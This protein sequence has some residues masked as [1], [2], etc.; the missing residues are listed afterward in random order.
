MEMGA[1]GENPTKAGDDA[2]LESVVLQ[3]VLD[4]HPGRV[5]TDELVL[6]LIGSE[7]DFA[8]RDGV[9]RAILELVHAGLLHPTD[10]GF[11]TPTRAAVRLGEILGPLT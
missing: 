2:H 11:V 3:R 6:D 8:A 7:P 4:L 9:E 5:T 10:D 1:P